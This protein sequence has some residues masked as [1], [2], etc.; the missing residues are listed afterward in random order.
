[1][2]FRRPV[3]YYLSRFHPKQEDAWLGYKSGRDLLLDWGRRSGKSALIA[4]IMIEAIEE[5]GKDCLYIALT[6]NQA[7]EIMWPTLFQKL[8]DNKKWKSNEQRL[9]WKYLPAHATLSLKGADLGKDRLRGSAKKVI[10]LD[11]MAFFRDPSIVK[12][13]LAPQLADYNGQFIF[14]STPKGRN[15]FWQLKQQ[16]NVDEDRYYT[17]H[18]TMFD[19]PYISDA[20]RM[21]I[22]REYTGENDPLYRQ[23]IMAEYIDYVGLVFALPQDSYVE[24][25]WEGGVLEHSY[26]W[27]GVDHGFQDPTACVWIAHNERKGHLHVYNEYKEKKMLVHQHTDTIKSLEPYHFVDTISDIDPQLIAEYGSLGLKMSPAGKYDRESRLLRLV[28]MLKTGKLKIAPH[29]TKLLSEM[30]RLEWDQP[31]PDDH[32]VDALLYVATNLVI[33][34]QKPTEEEEVWTARQNFDGNFESQNFE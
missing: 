33:P 23:E 5:S 6:Q 24:P 20:G 7:R 29:C 11:E 32:L 28:N 3:E 19:N 17:S 10:A 26:H 25:L 15:H 31:N 30:Q 8:G 9:E 1:M 21:R 34:E 16:A 14:C 4:E 27:R 13:V 2:A 12:D 22:L 18:C